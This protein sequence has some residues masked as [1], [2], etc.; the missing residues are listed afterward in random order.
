MTALV[1]M[2]NLHAWEAEN[3]HN[4]MRTHFQYELRLNVWVAVVRQ[5]SVG[6]FILPG[7]LNNTAYAEFLQRDLPPLLEYVPLNTRRNMW[8]LHDGAPSHMGAPVIAVIC[9]KE[10]TF[11]VA[12]TESRSKYSRLLCVGSYENTSVQWY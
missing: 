9:R 4:I 6:P 7:R 11:F 12:S 1:N 2:Q 10:C 3:P 8:L 5:N